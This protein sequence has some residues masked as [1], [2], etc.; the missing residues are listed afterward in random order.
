MF[1]AL[2]YQREAVTLCS[3][4]QNYDFWQRWSVVLTKQIE[5]GVLLS[6]YPL[7]LEEK[8]GLER[9]IF[10]NASLAL[11]GGKDFTFVPIGKTTKE[12]WAV[13]LTPAWQVVLVT[14]EQEGEALFSFHPQPV[15]LVLDVL[16]TYAEGT[17]LAE[18]LAPF[19]LQI[20]KYEDIADLMGGFLSVIHPVEVIIPELNDVEILQSMIHEVRTPLTSIRTLVHSLLRRSD[21]TPIVKQRLEQ[22]DRE[23]TDQI[24]RL[25]LIFQIVEQTQPI[26]R[27][28]LSLG[29]VLLSLLPQWQW[30]TARRN[31]TLEYHPEELPLIISN[32]E[33]LHQLLNSL[34]DRL[35]RLLPPHSKIALGTT[36]AGNFVKLEITTSGQGIYPLRPIGR[37]L[38][39]QP[40]TG[41]ISLN[42]V[43]TKALFQSLG[44]KF[45]LKT[46]PTG[47]VLTVFLPVLP[48]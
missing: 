47:E 22:I 16:L 10:G 25:N 43:V 32:R 1:F 21:L 15:R 37:W 48:G 6:N 5:T 35:F 31:L 23:A 44:G 12:K 27:E 28:S 29:D 3:P 40:E 18:R 14:G 26:L 7:F 41:V 24:D 42:L 4:Q 36:T 9:W 8:E 34:I 19:V 30:Q 13:V 33:L 45:T 39:F 11:P 17:K 2:L 20:P 38:L 46:I